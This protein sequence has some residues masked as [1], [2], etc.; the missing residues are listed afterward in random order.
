MFTNQQ[1]LAIA[2][3]HHT[4]LRQP[5]RATVAR[6][7]ASRVWIALVAA[8]VIV[9][10]PTAWAYSPVVYQQLPDTSSA[11]LAVNDTQPR[12]LAD[13][14]P[15]KQTTQI[16]DLHVYGS[17]LSDNLPFLGASDVSFSLSLHTDNGLS[18]SLPVN[19]P[20]WQSTTAPSA[21]S[22][23]ATSPQA[24]VDPSPAFLGSDTM[25]FEYDFNI[26]PITLGPGIYWLNV[27]AQPGATVNG[28][29]A[30]FGWA[31]TSPRSNLG[32]AAAWGSAALGNYPAVWNS[33]ANNAALPPF[34]LAFAITGVP[35][36]EPSTLSM[37]G[38]GLAALVAQGYRRHR[39]RKAKSQS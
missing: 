20:L 34:N 1:P 2:N 26:A 25:I 39:A 5:N 23:Y 37:A 6:S 32:D 27:E 19:P 14:F 22:L 21:T 18:P 29:T 28:V 33:S 38:V 10:S 16:T 7:R 8:F 9:A 4:I 24:F 15:L 17:F 30:I 31:D 35:V 11:A 3:F 12:I 36:P 13:D